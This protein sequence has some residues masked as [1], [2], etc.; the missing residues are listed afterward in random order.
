MESYLD[1]DREPLL[2]PVGL[3]IR[4]IPS[5]LCV[6]NKGTCSAG[7]VLEAQ[8][9]GAGTLYGVITVPACWPRC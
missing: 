7:T 9:A 1:K 6:L 4:R 2:R 5:A 3:S 8:A